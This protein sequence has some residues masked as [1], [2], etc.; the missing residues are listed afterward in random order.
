MKN[1]RLPFMRESD[2]SSEKGVD[3]PEVG[4]D[5][6]DPLDLKK[7]DDSDPSEETDLESESLE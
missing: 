1:L 3:R 2:R 7:F 4:L 5:D 6:R